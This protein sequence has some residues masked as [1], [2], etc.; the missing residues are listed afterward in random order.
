MKIA[1]FSDTFLPQTNGVATVTYHLAEMLSELGNEVIV[2]TAAHRSKKEAIKNLGN[3]KVVFYPS[4]P[5][6]VYPGERVA[7]PFGASA[8][9]KLIKFNPDIVH[10]HTPFSLG[11]AATLAAKVLRAKFVGTHHT[12]YDHY[13]KHVKMDYDWGKKLSWKYTVG[14]YNFCDLVMSPTRSLA[15]ELMRHGLKKKIMIIPNPV[16]T[17]LFIPTTKEKKIELKKKFG[18]PG[19]SIIHMG[20][21]SYEKNIYKAIEAFA[22][23]AEK[24]KEIRLMVVGDGPEKENLQNFCVKLGIKDKVI[25]TGILRGKHLAEA[26][27]AN[28]VFIS[29]S[30]SENMP[31]AFLEAMA[32]GL[33]IVAV[34]EKGISEIVSEGERGF[35]SPADNTELMANNI[36]KIISN[37]KL[38]AEMSLKAR[39]FAE[40]YS[41][42]NIAKTVEKTYKNLLNGK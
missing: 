6:F 40:N 12:F 8:F 29:S 28:D 41:R 26:F 23:A 5:A 19:K 14:Y 24:N 22:S 7:L 9:V 31:L 16:D 34:S 18:I 1:I 2:F 4:I 27:D 37:D 3:F 15:D 39:Q 33:P 30:K 11:W 17:E 35:L 36:L 20:R 21:L 25:F 13:L 42:L 38:I 10:S 32:A